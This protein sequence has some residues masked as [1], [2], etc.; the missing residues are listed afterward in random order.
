AA[1]DALTRREVR[2]LDGRGRLVIDHRFSSREAVDDTHRPL[3]ALT[4]RLVTVL[5]PAAGHE[6]DG[7]VRLRLDFERAT[8]VAYPGRIFSASGRRFEIQP[9]SSLEEV[10]EADF[11][12][13]RSVDGH[14]VTWRRRQTAVDEVEC[15]RSGEEI[16]SA[17]G[18]RLILVRSVRLRYEETVLGL[19]RRRVR[20]LGTGAGEL[21]SRRYDQ[22]LFGG[23]STRGL[24]MVLNGAGDAATPL[25]LAS[26]A[27][28]L[29]SVTGV[30][31]GVEED[32]LEWVPMEDVHVH[33]APTRGLAIVE[34]FPGGLGV[35]DA[36]H[37]ADRLVPSLLDRAQSW[38]RSCL[39]EDD[40][41]CPR[42]LRS[43][44][45]L[46][47]SGHLRPRRADALHVLEALR[48]P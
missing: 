5:D 36:L 46:A 25:A 20:S 11:L 45:A 41:G 17:D 48:G 28:A 22:P 24:L 13:C 10:Q 38:L 2:Y 34:L 15:P 32:V 44:L 19:H 35:L 42:C 12:E 8:V 27:A 1:S 23:F 21:E 39:C 16:R 14:F 43:P 33:G 29:R 30:H 18:F 3:D 31:L 40:L 6:A 37:D 4:R 26:L 47:S 7:G 9:W